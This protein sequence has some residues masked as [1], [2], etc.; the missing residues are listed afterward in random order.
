MARLPCSCL[1]RLLYAWE[2][3]AQFAGVAGSAC[4][5]CQAIISSFFS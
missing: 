4:T 5:H 3:P 1:P 2:V